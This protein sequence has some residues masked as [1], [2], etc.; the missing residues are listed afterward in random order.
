MKNIHLIF[1]ISLIAILS[2]QTQTALGKNAPSSAGQLRSAVEAALKAKDTNAV[3]ALVNWKGV[4]DKMKPD[5]AG[6]I[7]FM[8]SREVA[9]VKLL[10][11]PLGRQF[12]N[13]LN[14][15]RYYPNVHVQGLID[16]EFTAKG[17]ASQIPYGESNGAFYIA[18]VVQEIFDPTAKP[19][20]TLDVMVS[21]LFSKESPGILKC[22]YVYLA[23]GKEKTGSFQCTNNL[24]YSF[25]GDSF[26]SCTVTKLSGDGMIQLMVKEAGKTVFDSDVVKTNALVYEKK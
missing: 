13:E 2:L 4:S 25:W 11:L 19:S 24:S 6:Q 8:A 18:G 12:T 21:G 26:K 10:P 22:S 3:L 1:L 14:G 16:I 17:N 7:V 20:V 15:V 9:G 23:G 5:L